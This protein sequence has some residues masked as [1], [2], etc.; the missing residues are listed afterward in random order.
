LKEARGDIVAFIDEDAVP[1]DGWLTALL[2]NFEDPMVAVVTGITLPWELETPAQQWF[3]KTNSF[4]R[5]FERRSFEAQHMSI[6]GAGQVGAGVNMAL[7]KSALGEIGTFD[8]ALDGGT[9][10]LSGGD[11]EFFYRVLAHGYRIVYEPGAVVRHR[12]RREWEELRRTLFGYGVG[13]YAWWARALWIE[14]EWTT[15]FWGLRWFVQQQVGNLLR[16]FLHR[17]G[18]IPLDLAWAEFWGALAGPVRYLRSRRRSRG[19][20]QLVDQR[21]AAPEVEKTSLSGTET[22]VT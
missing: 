20:L 6:L 11:Q 4:G 3:E 5:G 19:G 22:H 8:E 1:D 21:N 14:G 12:H 18:H 7:R 16:A 13:L 10:T 2:R 9:P 15:L 17:P